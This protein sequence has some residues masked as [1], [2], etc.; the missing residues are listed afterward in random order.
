MAKANA[1][2]GATV[3]VAEG[4]DPPTD[5]PDEVRRVGPGG[6][7]PEVESDAEPEPAEE[8]LE[9]APTAAEAQPDVGSAEPE[10]AGP[11]FGVAFPAAPARPAVNDPKV[12]W[13][14]W[15]VS[16]GLDP[17]E[18]ADM[19]KARLQEWRP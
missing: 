8:D 11:E 14:A 19:S 10:P 15:A 4:Q 17:D 3:Y 7:E 6:P 2:S 9:A 16:C 18:A 5:L 1:V 13:V 12:A